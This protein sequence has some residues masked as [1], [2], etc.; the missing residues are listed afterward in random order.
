[1]VS[2]GK[3]ERRG[4]K[5]Q[6]AEHTI[7]FSK[8]TVIQ[9][10]IGAHVND[11]DHRDPRMKGKLDRDAQS[12]YMYILC[13]KAMSRT[14]GSAIRGEKHKWLQQKGSLVMGRWWPRVTTA[15]SNQCH[16]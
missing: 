16:Q 14:G 4:D 12:I 11:E 8:S 3:Q 7:P 1:M 6:G 10:D 9:R 2:P 15:I 5:A 13:G